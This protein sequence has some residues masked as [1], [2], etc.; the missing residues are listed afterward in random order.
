MTELSEQKV[1][2]AVYSERQLEEV[3]TDFWFN[4]FNVYA[5]KGATR[6]YL[7][8]YERDAIRPHVLGKFRDLLGATAKSPAMLFYP[9]QL[10]E[11]RDPRRTDH[12]ARRRGA[13]RRRTEARPAQTPVGPARAVQ[14]HVPAAG[15][16]RPAG[17][18]E[19][20][21][22][23]PQ[24][25]LRARADGAAHARRRRRL[26]AEGRHRG[27]ARVHRLDDRRTRG[28]AAASSSS[29]ACTTTGE[30]IVLGHEIK[31]GGGK[32]DG[33][34]VLDIL[35]RASVDGALH[36][37]QAGAAVRRRHAAAGAR[38]SRGGAVPRD[39]RRHPRGDA[40]DPHVAG[41]LLRPRPIA[42]RSRRRSS[43]SSARVRATGAD[44]DERAAAR[45]ARC[46]SSACRST[47]ASRRPAT[48]TRADA[49][50]NTGALVNRMN[51]ALV[52]DERPRSRRPCDRRRACQR[53]PATA[54]D[55]LVAGVLGG[56]LSASTRGHDRESAR[57]RRRPSR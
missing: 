7:T 20:A 16:T 10:A 14:M 18:A 27:R 21:A 9:R 50:V 2:R 24:R 17:G 51:F 34:Q 4:H 26:H 11:Q 6:G 1:L 13:E 29:R 53:D 25:E 3:L 39:R 12:G 38:R 23:R 5:G 22:A 15:A 41:V 31:A 30:K 43:S 28:R 57:R 56:D 49:W 19:R 32:R 45:A 35:A 42:R 46:S 33:E 37:D 8:E 54:R 52:A 36:R 48:P 44:V 55:A 47:C 40:D